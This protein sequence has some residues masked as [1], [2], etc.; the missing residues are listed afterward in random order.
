MIED[1]EGLVDDRL[2][3]TSRGLWA[4]SETERALKATLS[5]AKVRRLESGLI[6]EGNSFMELFESWK[7]EYK[8]CD[9]FLIAWW[10]M[11]CLNVFIK[12]PVSRA[13]D[14]L[15]AAAWVLD[16]TTGSRVGHRWAG[17]GHR[18]AACAVTW[19]AQT[20]SAAYHRTS[21]GD[22]EKKNPICHPKCDLREVRAFSL[23]LF[24]CEQVEQNRI[25]LLN[26]RAVAKSQLQ[27][28]LGQFL[29]LNN[30]EK[31]KH[32]VFLTLKEHYLIFSYVFAQKSTH[33][34]PVSEPWS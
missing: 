7:K 12:M 8:V 13:S 34:H 28:K 11:K 23:S 33:F 30:L 2:P 1:E 25:K 27:K 5:F 10:M 15:S 32:D 9:R 17:N 19:W 29:Y 16:V 20:Q 26:D 31:V 21:R 6:E 22:D 14:A 18:E 3:T 4:A 24:T